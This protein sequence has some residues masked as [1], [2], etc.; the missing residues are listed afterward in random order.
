MT[1]KWQILSSFTQPHLCK[2]MSCLQEVAKLDISAPNEKKIAHLLPRYDGYVANLKLKLSPE[3]LVHCP[4]LKVVVTPTTGTDHLPLP[5]L[6]ERGIKLISLR[7]SPELL[8]SITATAEL[9]WGLLLS[10]IRHIP[11]SFAAVRQGEW[12]RDNFIGHQLSGKTIG[13]IGYGRL[14]KIVAN[15]ARAFGM[16]VLVYDIATTAT[17]PAG[18]ISVSLDELLRKSDIISLHIHLD[19]QNIGFIGAVEMDKMKKTAI[20]L[21]SSRGAIIDETAL[22]E[23]LASGR[24]AGAAVDVIDG[25][26]GDV[27]HHPMVEYAKTHNNLLLTPHIGGAVYEAQQLAVSHT[28][29]QLKRFIKT[30]NKEVAAK[31]A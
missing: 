8:K 24:L 5:Y 20:I 21:N 6:E 31:T 22:L 27:S 15:Y 23:R 10:L 29:E 4:K 28:S 17:L 30:T 25:E 14:G 13:I 3:L 12:Q 18:I 9:T 2:A 11:Q 1:S 26:W 7:Q 19:K 16:S